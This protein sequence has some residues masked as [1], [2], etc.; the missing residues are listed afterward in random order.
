VS[1]GAGEQLRLSPNLEH[2][3]CP[4]EHHLAELEDGGSNLWPIFAE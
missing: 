4:E 3:Y 2:P 1:L